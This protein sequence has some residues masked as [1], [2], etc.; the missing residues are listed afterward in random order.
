MGNDVSSTQQPNAKSCRASCKSNGG[1]YF[2]LDLGK[3]RCY[4]KYSNEGRRQLNDHISGE[5]ACKSS[6]GMT[7][8]KQ[9]TTTSTRATSRSVSRTHVFL[10]QWT[11]NGNNGADGHLASRH[12]EEASRPQQGGLRNKHK[13][14]EKTVWDE[15]PKHSNAT[16][17]LAQV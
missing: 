2:T 9:A 7:S 13:M 14:E 12:V 16:Q 6:T 3:K 10:F 11:A 1:N 8:T 4:C 5:T 15:Q 17:I